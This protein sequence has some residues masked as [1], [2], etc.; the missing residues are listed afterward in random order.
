M[1]IMNNLQLNDLYLI[2]LAA[3]LHDIGKFCQRSNYYTT[4]DKKNLENIYKYQHAFFTYQYLNELSEILKTSLNLSNEEYNNLIEISAR[5][6]NPIPNDIKNQ[7]LNIADNLSSTERERNQKSHVNL[8]HPIFQRISFLP[9]KEIKNTSF[10]K[11]SKLYPSEDTIFPITDNNIYQNT[12]EITK[13]YK[14]LFSE[15]NN[16]IKNIKNF[17]G[18]K[19]FNYIYYLLEKYLWSVPSSTYDT[20]NLSQHYSDISLFDHLRVVAM[21]SVALLDYYKNNEIS[22]INFFNNNPNKDIFLIIEVNIGGIQNFIYNIAKTPSIEEFSISKSLRG[23][24]L[25]ITLLTELIARN[26]LKELNYP[27][28]NI[29]YSRRRKIS[30]NSSKHYHKPNQTKKYRTKIN[31]IPI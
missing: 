6:H 30:N 19:A 4:W 20:Q 13:Q 9:E 26:L 8:L 31:T 2:A 15:F 22:D 5:H 16:E 21:I 12:N 18:I 28:T 10:Y 11:I 24:S 1:N 3:L 7:I 29:L 14:N 23:R 27:I 25:L 17:Q